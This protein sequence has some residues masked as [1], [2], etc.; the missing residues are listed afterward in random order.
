M[1]QLTRMQ[2]RVLAFV[3]KHIKK[4][5]Y[6]PTR[7]EICAEF[8]W[9]S[10]TSAEDHLRAIQRKGYIRIPPGKVARGIQVL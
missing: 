3:E 10:P 8:D 6:P 1:K 9:A 5:G 2:E 7:M 4:N